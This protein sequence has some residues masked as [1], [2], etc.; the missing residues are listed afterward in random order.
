M[1][2]ECVRLYN[3]SVG[4]DSV[5][6]PS[7]ALSLIWTILH[8]RKLYFYV[9]V[10]LLFMALFQAIIMQYTPSEKYCPNSI[11]LGVISH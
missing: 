5:A 8:W 2:P 3:S 7:E 10:L 6:A 1:K 4:T 11:S 9:S